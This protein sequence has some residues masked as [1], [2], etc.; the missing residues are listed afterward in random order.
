MVKAWVTAS[1]S[2]ASGGLA[3]AR[4][5]IDAVLER[6]FRPLFAERAR[7]L[8]GN[9]GVTA[10][11]RAADASVARVGFPPASERLP[12]ACPVPT[13]YAVQENRP[14]VMWPGPRPDPATGTSAQNTSV[15]EDIAAEDSPN[16]GR[17]RAHR[18]AVDRQ[19]VDVRAQTKSQRTQIHNFL[20]LLRGRPFERFEKPK[21]KPR[22]FGRTPESPLEKLQERRLRLRYLTQL[23]EWNAKYIEHLERQIPHFGRVRARDGSPSGGR[24]AD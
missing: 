3:S 4:R 15:E 13:L 20:K 22:R 12:R 1:P 8:P 24:P 5:D 17:L 6:R 19:L 16:P 18:T 9:P 11:S 7:V 23:R 2:Q 21:P 14:V 10:T